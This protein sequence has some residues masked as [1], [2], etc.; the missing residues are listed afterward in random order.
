MSFAITAAVVGG[1]TAVSTGMQIKAQNEALQEQQE[2]VAAT[3]RMNYA[4]KQQQEQ[5]LKEQAG[6]EKTKVAIEKFQERGKIQAAQAESGVAGASPLREFA[7]TYLQ[8]SLT[9]GSITATTASKQRTLALENQSTYLQGL[10]QINQLESQKTDESAAWMQTIMSGVQG[11]MSTYSM[12]SSM[13]GYS[14]GATT[15]SSSTQGISRGLSEGSTSSW[16]NSA[17]GG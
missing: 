9:Q 16:G 11:G 17:I 13:G 1:L 7:N 15:A 2:S 8:E 3:T 5:E 10:S 6:L 14:S 12:G 4:L